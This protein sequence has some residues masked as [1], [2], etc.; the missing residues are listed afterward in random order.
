ME[1]ISRFGKIF[2][3]HLDKM[4]ILIDSFRRQFSTYAD[5]NHFHDKRV[6]G[7]VKALKDKL[8]KSVEA[9]D[10]SL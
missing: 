6:A 1:K 10:V 9:L 3:Y 4:G 7:H 2:E 5:F 8:V